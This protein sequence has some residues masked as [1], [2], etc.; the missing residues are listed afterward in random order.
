MTDGKTMDAS[1]NYGGGS[2]GIIPIT[3][4]PIPIT[5]LRY[6]WAWEVGI[7]NF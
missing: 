6:V 5:K 7:P 4:L 3:A 1:S 2:H